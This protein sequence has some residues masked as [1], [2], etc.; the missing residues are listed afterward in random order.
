MT[1]LKNT[2]KAVAALNG[3]SG[4]ELADILGLT[5]TQA[6]NTKFHRNSFSGQD[7][8]KLAE[9][10]DYDLAFVNKEGKVVIRFP[11]EGAEK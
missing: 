10:C 2:V 1:S 6:L 11:Q 7:L 3:L 9:A 4:R 8:L 5:Y